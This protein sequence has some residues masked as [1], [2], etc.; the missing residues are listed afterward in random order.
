MDTVRSNV[1]LMHKFSAPH[2]NLLVVSLQIY[3]YNRNC[4]PNGELISSTRHVT[5]IVIFIFLKIIMQ[6]SHLTQPCSLHLPIVKINC[7]LLYKQ[8]SQHEYLLKYAW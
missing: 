8:L 2:F 5:L 3:I 6:L 7:Y 1:L 4:F